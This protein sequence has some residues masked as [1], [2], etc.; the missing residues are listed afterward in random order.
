MINAEMARKDAENAKKDAL[1][2]A[3]LAKKDAEMSQ[4]KN[5]MS[6]MAKII[7]NIVYK[8]V[9]RFQVPNFIILKILVFQFILS[10]FSIS[11]LDQ[12]ILVCDVE[13]PE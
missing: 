12:A 3:E 9:V 4:I 5:Q 10:L 8:C 1:N 6:E 7:N 13:R 11:R 2:A